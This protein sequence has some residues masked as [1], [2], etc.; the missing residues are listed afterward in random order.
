MKRI[1]G[2]EDKFVTRNVL[3]PSADYVG[4]GRRKVMRLSRVNMKNRSVGDKLQILAGELLTQENTWRNNYNCL[5][6]VRLELTN[7][8]KDTHVSFSATCWKYADTF[9]ML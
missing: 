4:F 6:D 9:R 7:S 2:G 8:I 3:V 5:W 1:I